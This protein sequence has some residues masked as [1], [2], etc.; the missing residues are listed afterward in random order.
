M[1]SGVPTRGDRRE[2][3]RPIVLSARPDLSEATSAVGRADG[4]WLSVVLSA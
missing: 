4:P 1:Q 2:L 3:C